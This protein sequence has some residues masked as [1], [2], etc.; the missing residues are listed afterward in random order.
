MMAV[1]IGRDPSTGASQVAILRSDGSQVGRVTVPVP[2]AIA[3]LRWLRDGRLAA[4]PFADDLAGP[5][6]AFL[7]GA[8]RVAHAVTWHPAGVRAWSSRG[9]VAIANDRGIYVV[10][11]RHRTR[12]LLLRTSRRFHYGLPDWSPDAGRLVVTRLDLQTSLDTIITV[13]VRRGRS[14][15][16][17]RRVGAIGPFGRVVWSPSGRRLAFLVGGDDNEGAVYTVRLD[18]ADLR[19]V[20]D[21]GSVGR[22]IPLITFMGP[23]LS[24]QPLTA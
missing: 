20:F 14:R 12:R 9:D 5:A 23:Q 24:W 4:Y 16:V 19:R 3:E 2:T 18:G 22:G 1:V 10:D 15:I 6:E 21:L 8:D 11:G 13:S 17:V 7:I